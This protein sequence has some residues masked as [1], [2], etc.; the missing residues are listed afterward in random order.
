VLSQNSLEQIDR[1][2]VKYPA[3]RKRSAVI[4]SLRIA[5]EEHGWLSREVMDFIAKRLELRP[6]EVYEVAT[7]YTMFDLEPHGRH[8]ICVCTNVSCMLCGS[9]GLL[10]HIRKRYGAGLG[11]TTADGRFTFQEV[12]C[13]CAC[14]GA[15]VVQIGK[16]YYEN[17]TPES[18]DEMLSVLD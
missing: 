16:R 14:A 8:K 11:E 3:E 5:Q 9:D 2:L 4:A 1:E 6:I 17:V 15:P 12:E 13:L 10:E 7:F 18:L